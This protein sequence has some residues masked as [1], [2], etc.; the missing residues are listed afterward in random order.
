VYALSAGWALSFSVL[1]SSIAT[2]NLAGAAFSPSASLNTLPLALLVISLSAW[3]FALPRLFQA[4]GGRARA[5]RVTSAVGVAAAALAACACAARSFATLCLSSVALGL[6]AAAGQT[7][8]FAVLT[9]VPAESRPRCVGL[10]LTGGVVGAVLG[11]GYAAGSRDLFPEA[12][13]AGVY[14]CAA[15]A[16]A[17]L[18][19]VV[20][21][22]NLVAF[23]AEQGD[24]KAERGDDK[25]SKTTVNKGNTDDDAAERVPPEYPEAS[26]PE[27]SSPEA[28]SESGD[29]ER[30]R[31]PSSAPLAKKEPPH[32]GLAES[33]AFSRPRFVAAVFVSASSYAAM[34]FLMSP[35]PLAM[36]A[37]GYSFTSVT[38]V[39]AG[40]MLG[41]YA[42]SFFS[43]AATQRLGF[44][45]VA[46]A[47]A[48]LLAVASGVLRAGDGL[49]HFAAGQAILGVGWNLC[50]VA[51]PAEVG[52]GSTSAAEEAAKA[53]GRAGD[54]AFV[55]A[56]AQRAQSRADVATF[57]TAGVAS[58]V[59][60]AALAH[61]GWEDM[62]IVGWAAALAALVA[63]AV[64]RR[65]EEGGNISEE[66]GNISEE[67]RRAE[68]GRVA[69]PPS[70]RT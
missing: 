26:S 33:I 16:Y 18:L 25:A 47:G 54:A 39:I 34:S 48:A 59:S 15:L 10:V 2:A 11:P 32:S 53:A 60:G 7:F 6:P 66:G 41:M 17:T 31:S 5:Y 36:R 69:S 49:A 4:V 43:G 44:D 3:S 12:E 19:A 67:G 57:A 58:V 46:A 64:A 27:A 61:A 22:P 42:P 56:G 50:F 37:L 51:S 21:A 62:Q 9:L 45:R 20:L 29:P 14:L 8:R 63:I 38:F 1:T 23:P 68:E 24:D 55:A 40:H 65:A 52:R 30:G 28:S 70:S 13:F 35:T